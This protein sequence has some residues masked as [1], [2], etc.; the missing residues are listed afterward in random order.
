MT[1]TINTKAYNQDA[2]TSA[3]SIPY[4]GPAAT[5]AIK[6]RLELARTAAKGNSSYSG[7]ARSRAKLTRTTTLTG[8]KTTSGDM[9]FDMG[10]S[11]PIGSADAA[12]DTA[13]DDAAAFIGSAVFKDLVKKQRLSN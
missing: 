4:N 9:I 2:A 1:I 10:T 11:V 12:I 3:N 6:D 13:C 5:L 8:A 7:N